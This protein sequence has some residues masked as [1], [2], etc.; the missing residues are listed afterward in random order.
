MEKIEKN[1]GLPAE[2]RGF[3]LIETMLVVVL[4]AIALGLSIL[5]SQTSQLR[6]DLNTQASTIV[7][8]LRLA[9][10]NAIAGNTN[11]I[12]A[13]HLGNN[14]YTLFVGPT[15]D[16]DESS[17]YTPDIPPTITIENIVL[18]GGGDDI[19]FDKSNG[20]TDSYGTF[21]IKSNQ[22]NKS[23]TITILPI[24]TISY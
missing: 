6:A 2:R 22:I 17:N 3:T 4:F 1:K 23:V 11:E 10:S 5:Y 13:M 19:I 24:G 20:E 9:Q 8:Y 15:Y 7:S 21:D 18:N 14:A 12:N 16:P